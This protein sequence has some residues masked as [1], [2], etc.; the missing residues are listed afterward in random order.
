MTAQL[1]DAR[2]TCWQFVRDSFPRCLLHVH[3]PNREILE[4]Q[5][6]RYTQAEPP[7][8]IRSIYLTLID[9]RLPGFAREST[10]LRNTFT[11]VQI[12]R[13]FHSPNF[14]PIALAKCD[15]VFAQAE[16]FHAGLIPNLSPIC[17]FVDTKILLFVANDKVLIVK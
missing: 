1:Y 7:C 10:Y 16:L 2:G 5:L 14:D 9:T 15:Y 3:A 17:N 4:R 13:L 12:Q 11:R 6:C 8:P